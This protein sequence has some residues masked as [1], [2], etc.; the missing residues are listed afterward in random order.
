MPFVSDSKCLHGTPSVTPPLP[1]PPPF[2]SPDDRAAIWA[3]KYGRIANV[4]A[5]MWPECTAHLGLSLSACLFSPLALPSAA[6][7]TSAAFFCAAACTE[8]D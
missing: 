8:Q 2:L 4:W 5:S 7:V 6:L 3:I 1:S